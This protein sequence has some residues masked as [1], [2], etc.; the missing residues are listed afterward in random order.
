ME[1]KSGTK[2]SCSHGEEMLA[3]LYDELSPDGRAR[4][5]A[6]LQGCYECIDE[7]AELAVSRYSVFEWKSVEFAPMATPKFVIPTE[8]QPAKASWFNGIREAFAWKGWALA[9]GMAA[10]LLFGMIGFMLWNVPSEA[11][12][13]GNETEQ[14]PQPVPSVTQTLRS[15]VSNEPEQPSEP[16]TAGSVNEPEPEKTQNRRITP[17]RRQ[18]R[19][20]RTVLA[21]K[22]AT[23]ATQN[24][25]TGIQRLQNSPT[26]GQYVEDQDES[27][28]LS[29]IFDDLDTKDME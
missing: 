12:I 26:L 20:T 14:I 7:F 18:A 21:Q 16:A 28:R 5:E 10:M 24:R 11:T 27:L 19:A 17:Q 22:E 23:P 3:Y 25:A 9:G 13:A 1:M 8:N 4:F 15:T 29:D 2:F 6:H